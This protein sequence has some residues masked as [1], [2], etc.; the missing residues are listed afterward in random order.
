MAALGRVLPLLVRQPVSVVKRSISTSPRSLGGVYFEKDFFPGPYPKTE[1][2][3]LKAAKKYG[4]QPEDYKPWENHDKWGSGDYPEIQPI[5]EDLKSEY[6]V[7]D[8]KSTKTNFNE[9]LPMREYHYTDRFDYGQDLYPSS[10][11]LNS[12]HSPTK[13]M[14]PIGINQTSSEIYTTRLSL[15]SQPRGANEEILGTTPVYHST[16]VGLS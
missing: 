16:T 3:R 9:P 15:L 4:M 14:V 1:E 5:G 7:W 8:D 10:D 11:Y 6:E 13:A 12:F 2:E